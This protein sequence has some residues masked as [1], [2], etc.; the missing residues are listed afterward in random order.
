MTS[1]IKDTYVDKTLFEAELRK[2][3][4]TEIFTE[5]L[6]EILLKLINGQL[7]SHKFINYSGYWREALYSKALENCVAAVRN[8]SYEM[9]TGA[10]AFGYYY[11]VV[12]NSFLT[13][14]NKQKRIQEGEDEY[15]DL[16]Y[17]RIMRDYPECY[18]APTHQEDSF[19]GSDD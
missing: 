1:T 9:D 17:S 18:V 14:I 7:F 2:Y 15:R 11:R 6:G 4:D 3:Y 5:E 19:D 13:A 16:E 12:F 8:K 10:S